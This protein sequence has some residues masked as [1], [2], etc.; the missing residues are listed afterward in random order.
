M[1]LVLL[2]PI[3]AF[4]IGALLTSDAGPGIAFGILIFFAFAL[5][6]CEPIRKGDENFAVRD[7]TQIRSAVTG[8]GIDGDFVL[9]SGSIDDTRFYAYWTTEGTNTNGAVE[10]RTIRDSDWDVEI[11]E[12][13]STSEIVFLEYKREE[14]W[15]KVYIDH[16]YKR[17]TIYVPQGTIRYN[18]DISAK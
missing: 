7:T 14:T 12:T 17:A 9:G 1:L 15:N 4:L 10:R 16:P 6:S 11:V 13:D 8:S 3:I 2:G 18:Y 5:Y